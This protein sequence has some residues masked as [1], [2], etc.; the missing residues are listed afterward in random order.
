[1]SGEKWKE[2]REAEIS[3]NYLGQLDQAMGERSMFKPANESI[4][5]SRS[6]RGMRKHLLEIICGVAE[7]RF[8]VNWVYSENLHRRETIE[9]VAENYIESLRKLIKH[10][11]SPESGGYTPADFPRAKFSQEELDD[12]IEELSEAAGD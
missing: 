3:F 4:G 11:L 5:A 10:C 8:Q 6:P 1:L 7:G 12:L 2:E 9:M